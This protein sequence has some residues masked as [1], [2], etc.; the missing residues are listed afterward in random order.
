MAGLTRMGKM[1]VIA[2][3]AAGCAANPVTGKKELQVIS[4]SQEISIGEQNYRVMQQ[5]QGGAYTAD[6]KVQEYVSKVGSRLVQMSDRSTLP[7]EFVVL[8]NSVPNAWAL[9]GGKI[10]INRGLLEQLHSEAELS[11]VL[12][13]EIVHSAARHGAKALER[14]LFMETGMIGLQQ[15][16]KDHKYENVFITGTSVGAGLIVLKYSRD[17]ELEADKYG[18]KYMAAAGY[19]PQAAVDLQKLFL[20]MS[21]HQNPSW[22][23]GIVSTHPPSEERIRANES[24]VAQYPAG[25]ETGAKEY[26]KAMERI[27]KDQDAYDN[28]DRGYEALTK[29]K[30]QQALA[31]AQKGIDLQPREG[32][33]YNLKGKSESSLGQYGEALESFSRAI[34]LNPNYFDFYL[35]KGL[36]EYKLG[37]DH[38]AKSDLRISTELLPSA[39]AHYTLGQIELKQ[40]YHVEALR[41]F[42]IAAQADSE[43]GYLAGKEAAKMDLPRNPKEYILVQ[44][45]G[46]LHGYLKLG[47]SNKS[48]VSV[49]NIVIQLTFYNSERMPSQR[50]TVTI[51]ETIEPNQKIIKTTSI[52][53]PSKN[54]SIQMQVLRVEIAQ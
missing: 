14:G 9:P 31:L 45:E 35:Q 36:L 29:G 13:H 12:S 37:D 18:I 21:H 26:E 24:T 50:R 34:K 27:K 2:C 1:L 23:G 43:W 49:K 17:A 28:L 32:H 33:L 41:H 6:P 44:T 16:L 8:N 3:L 54:K 11:D 52:A 48:A 30:A 47:I 7:Y 53:P 4:E 10:A 25:G 42:K 19:N 46:L 20:K 38:S 40:G 22:L 5:A 39:Q 51:T 15:I